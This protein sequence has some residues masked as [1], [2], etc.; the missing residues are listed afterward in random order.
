M[1]KMLVHAGSAQLLL[2]CVPQGMARGAGSGWKAAV[3]AHTA[4]V[5]QALIT[6]I[7]VI[8]GNWWYY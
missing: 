8:G 4:L 2:P 5:A 3:P 6:V 1:Q 7:M